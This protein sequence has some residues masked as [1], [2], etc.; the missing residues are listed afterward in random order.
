MEYGC[1]AAD[2][3]WAH[4]LPVSVGHPHDLAAGGFRAWDPC[5]ELAQLCRR[6]PGAVRCAGVA[7]GCAGWCP[8]FG[9]HD[10]A[11]AAGPRRRAAAGEELFWAGMALGLAALVGAFAE[12]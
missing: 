6:H 4:C 8:V 9:A 1:V 2:P 3:A 7:T 10:P 5:P 12:L 11:H